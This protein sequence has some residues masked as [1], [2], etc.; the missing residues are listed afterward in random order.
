MLPLLILL[1]LLFAACS[2]KDVQSNPKLAIEAFMEAM[3]ES[4]HELLGTL[5]NQNPNKLDLSDIGMMEAYEIQEV[6]YVTKTEALA[7]V[8]ITLSNYNN[9]TYDI[10]CVFHL[11]KSD[12]LWYVLTAEM[13]PDWDQ[14]ISE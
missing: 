14:W 4:N 13:S 12:N 10:P 9:L 6:T 2:S 1:T 8:T 5:T 7:S 11:Y 3:E